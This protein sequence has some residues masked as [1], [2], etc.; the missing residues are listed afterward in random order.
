[1][2]ASLALVLALVIGG[3][4]FGCQGDPQKCEQ[5]VRNYTSLVFWASA[6]REI[7]SAAP[8]KQEA[9]RK[10]KLVEYNTQLERGLP[11]MVSQCQAAHNTDTINCM[12]AAKTADQAKGC[13]K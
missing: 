11:T 1:M 9:M 7:G 4:S 10:Q 5:A 8:D 12:A 2:R 3:T 13:E 6:D